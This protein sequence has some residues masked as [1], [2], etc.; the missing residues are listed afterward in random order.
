[1]TEFNLDEYYDAVVFDINGE[2]VGGVGQVFL[3]EES[4][5]PS[6][7]TVRTGLFGLK[8]SFV[9]LVEAR[10]EDG[11][12]HVAFSKEF[13]KDA[14]RQDPETPMTVAEEDA[15][16]AYY[17][18]EDEPEKV[19]AN[20][21]AQQEAIASGQAPADREEFQDADQERARE[22]ADD[23]EPLAPDAD[24]PVAD[25]DPLVADT[26]PLAP[27]ADRRVPLDDER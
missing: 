10:L 24:R 16:Q 6:W 7:V 17:G 1:M 5:Q 11:V 3:D 27:D 22:E 18:T 23:T 13:I 15:L 12:L 25:T 2:K 26:D 8:E 20:L 19:S 14:P 9:P 21:K 4:G